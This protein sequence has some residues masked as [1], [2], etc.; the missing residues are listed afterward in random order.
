M[1]DFKYDLLVIGAGPSGE[2]AAMAAVKNDMRVGVVEDRGMLGGNCTHRGTIPSKALRHAVKQVIHFG[3]QPI[4]R[5]LGNARTLSYPEVLAAASAVIPKQVALHT[6]YFQRNRVQVHNGHA[7]FIGDNQV[8][9]IDPDGVRDIISAKYF[10]IATGSRPYHP[11]EVDFDHPR[12]YDS[13]TIL[14]MKH[15]PR[16]LII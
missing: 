3:S 5:S 1:A 6:E 16:T 8:E 11:A 12:I 2:A 9:V 10:V 15:G 4:F 7:R 14:D 13:D